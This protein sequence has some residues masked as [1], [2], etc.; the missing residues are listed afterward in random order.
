MVRGIEQKKAAVLVQNVKFQGYSNIYKA[1]AN[2]VIE[3]TTK[4]LNTVSEIHDDMLVRIPLIPGFNDSKE[5]AGYFAE[6]FERN[7]N[8]KNV[9]FE[10]L[11]YHEF[12]K[13]KWEQCGMEYKMPNVR[14][15]TGTVKIFEDSMHEKGFVCVRT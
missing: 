2:I 11:A 12:G 9:Q 15:A 6:Y 10:F 7:I 5:D 14:L 13:Q 8:N 1:M 3:N 4:T